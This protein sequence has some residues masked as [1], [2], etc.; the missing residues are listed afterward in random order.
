MTH[1]DADDL[2]VVPFDSPKPSLDLLHGGGAINE[3]YNLQNLQILQDGQFVDD[4]EGKHQGAKQFR[5]TVGVPTHV[6]R[7]KFQYY[8]EQFGNI[9]LPQP[10]PQLA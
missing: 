7:L 6:R 3:G 4:R 10:L 8:T 1:W 5:A 9:D 2:R